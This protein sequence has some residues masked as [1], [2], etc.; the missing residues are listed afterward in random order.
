MSFYSLLQHHNEKNV[1]EF[2]HFSNV[3][4]ASILCQFCAN[5]LSILCQ[6][7]A[8]FLNGLIEGNNIFDYFHP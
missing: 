4:F 7:W 1:I 2:G 6:F 5:L 3:T 8:T